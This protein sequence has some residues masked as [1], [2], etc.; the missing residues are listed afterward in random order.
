MSSNQPPEEQARNSDATRAAEPELEWHAELDEL[1]RRRRFAAELGGA[2]AVAKHHAR[3]RRTARERIEA[4][5]DKGS[6][7]EVGTLAGSG[8]YDDAGNLVS[9]RPSNLIVGTGD[10]DQ[11]RVVISADDFTVRGGSSDASIPEK[12]LYRE[13]LAFDLGIPVVRLLDAGGGSIRS[14]EK[15]GYAPAPGSNDWSYAVA[16]L[17][18][19]PVVSACLGSVAGSAAAY[20]VMSHFCVMVAGA[21]Q[22]MVGGP[23][24][25]KGAFGED[26]TPEELGGAGVHSANGVA[27]CV[28]RDENDA[29]AAAR[30]F[31][32]YLP[33]NTTQL[34]PR[35]TPCARTSAEES[36]DSLTALANTIPRDR[37]RVYDV[38][39]LVSSL[40]DPGSVFELGARYARSQ[41][42]CLARINGRPV[43]VLASN[44]MF[45][46]GAMT[47][48]S[49]EKLIRFIDMC[50]TFHIPVVNIVDQPGIAIGS[51]AERRGTIRYA[52]RALA[53][54]YQARTPMIVIIVRRLF[55]V[56]GAAL[57]PGTGARRRYAWPSARWGSI[58]PEGGIEVAYRREIAAAA[59]PEQEKVRIGQQLDR[60]TSPFRTAEHFGIEEIIDPRETP[61]LL[62]EWSSDAYAVL[63]RDTGPRAY[64]LRP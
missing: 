48:Q 4:F 52:A 35:G 42:T 64:Q 54:V 32:S 14:M 38:R 6:F 34:P 10:V 16:N 5:L 60:L 8:Q 53:T 45:H 40:V 50:D 37:R 51:D 28:T 30:T 61:A 33:T 55:G 21:S 59:D 63:A 19:V 36:P 31:L 27:D 17:A 7:R 29:F 1:A 13:K 22:I 3:G 9:V 46:A 18:H 43:G 47:A 26:F 11:R 24:I 23:A 58:P 12:R 2:E 41:M 62:R 25:V 57:I 20:A 15:A 56:A 44:V 49:S 39:A